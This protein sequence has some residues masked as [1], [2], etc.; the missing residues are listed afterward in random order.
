[1][2]RHINIW[3]KSTKIVVVGYLEIELLDV[4]SGS[5]LLLYVRWGNAHWRAGELVQGHV[6]S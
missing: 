4:K 5:L 3:Y 1:M 2:L 6:V